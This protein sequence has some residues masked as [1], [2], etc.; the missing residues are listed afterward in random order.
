M[1]ELPEVET[2]VRE[3]RPVVVGQT[4]E[5][6]SVR[7]L[8]TLGGMSARVFGVRVRGA[9]F[10]AIRRRGKYVVFDLARHGTAAGS[11]VGHLR[12]SGRFA[13]R[14]AAAAP[15]AYLRVAWR[16]Q[17]G[18]HL[19]FTDVR[20]FGR[21]EWVQGAEERLASLGP[22]PLGPS[23]TPAWLRANLRL[24]R[25]QLKPLLLDQT[26]L[27]GLGNIYVDEALHRAGLHPQRSSHSLR[28]AASERLHAEIRA[29]LRE[30]IEEKGSSFDR[31]YRTPEGRPGAFQKRFR[32][33][34][35]AGEPCTQ[36][37]GTIRRIVVGQRGTH[38]C[39]RC[40]RAPRTTRSGR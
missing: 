31:L 20:K 12:M 14:E 11:L 23:F 16:L 32:V 24:R 30:A 33:Y 28:P 8:R 25:R 19:D 5:G 22:E 1:P 17:D 6:V 21:V 37:G 35:R 38:L 10:D 27:A 26:F 9:R 36:C 4:I 39:P 15:P 13:V 29:V 3:L 7:W 18:S 2:V 34:G 40:Q